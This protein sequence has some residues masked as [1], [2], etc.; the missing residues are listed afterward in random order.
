MD[1][2]LPDR[3]KWNVIAVN[4]VYDSTGKMSSEEISY[5]VS[6]AMVDEEW[7]VTGFEVGQ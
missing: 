1:D 3:I 7:K 4:D 5:W 2:V 6:V